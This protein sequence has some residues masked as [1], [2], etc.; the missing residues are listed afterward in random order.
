MSGARCEVQW[1]ANGPG[2]GS[3]AIVERPVLGCGVLCAHEPATRTPARSPTDSKPRP[4]KIAYVLVRYPTMSA[5][6]NIAAPVFG[7]TRYGTIIFP[8]RATN[9]GRRALPGATLCRTYAS[10]RLVSVSRT[11][12]EYGDAS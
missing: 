3:R 6:S 9:A 11:S 4:A 8:E 7:S 1:E 5:D 2:S 10:S 12:R